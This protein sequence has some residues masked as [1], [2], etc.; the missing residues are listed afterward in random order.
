MRSLTRIASFL[1]IFVGFFL[2]GDAANI[3]LRTC[4]ID[5][6]YSSPD[7]ISLLRCAQN[8]L[9]NVIDSPDDF[10]VLIGLSVFLLLLILPVAL[11]IIYRI[12]R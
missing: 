5:N 11:F 8:L 6:L 7:K 1:G 12:L 2:V 9:L 4:E 10:A 3:F